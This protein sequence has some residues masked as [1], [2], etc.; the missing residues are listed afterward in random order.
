[1]NL[2]RRWAVIVALVVFPLLSAGQCAD[3]LV[4]NADD[5]VRNADDAER[6]AQAG[7]YGDDITDI[8]RATSRAPKIQATSRI[9]GVVRRFANDEDTQD[10][11]RGLVWEVT[12]DVV[13][14]DIPTTADRI[15]SALLVR[16]VSFALEFTGDAGAAVAQA[17]LDAAGFG[18]NRSDAAEACSD[19]PDSGL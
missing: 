17:L 18:E 7:Q 13:T 19:I 8:L 14:G 16:S 3:D 11:L 2:S 5:L 10:A 6:L 4:R 9:D 15:A 1:M 12:C